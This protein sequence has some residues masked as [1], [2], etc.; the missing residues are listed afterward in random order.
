MISLPKL[1]HTSTFPDVE[2]ALVDPNGLLAFGGDLSVERLLSAYASGIFPWFG[3][4]EPIL[5]WS[6]DPRGVIFVDDYHPSK[7]L[8]KHIRRIKPQVSIN[9]AFDQVIDTCA[10]IP[11]TDNGTWITAEMIQGYKNLH[12]SGHA[13]SVEVWLDNELIGG[14]YGVYS[15]SVFCGESM[16]S[17]QTNG[18]KIALHYLVQYLARFKVKL[19][20]C[21][22][23]NPHLATLGCVTVARKQFLSYLKKYNKQPIQIP[24]LAQQLTL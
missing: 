21:Q 8:L 11:R 12:K 7:S 16:F 15:N 18:S 2:N 23:Q 5:W 9:L 3:E 13:H 24:W 10:H 14:L 4:G 22:M 1:D 19:I 20:D 6:P 17:K